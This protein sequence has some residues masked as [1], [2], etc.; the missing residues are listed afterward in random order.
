LV[1]PASWTEL[2]LLLCRVF[3]G[4]DHLSDDDARLGSRRSVISCETID[5]R[6]DR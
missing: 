2:P 3:R 4:L 1:L 5:D 6:M